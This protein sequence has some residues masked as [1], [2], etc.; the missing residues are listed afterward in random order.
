MVDSK[1]LIHMRKPSLFP[2][3]EIKWQAALSQAA[4]PRCFVHIASGEWLSHPPAFVPMNSTCPMFAR[5]V[6][7]EALSS[8]MAALWPGWPAVV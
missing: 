7:P 1:L 8:F 6:A 3:A 4:D 2:D 5:K